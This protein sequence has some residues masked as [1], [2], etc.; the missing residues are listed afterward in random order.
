MFSR[1]LKYSFRCWIFI[2]NYSYL[3]ITFL[4]R[5]TNSSSYDLSVS[6][7]C[8]FFMVSTSSFRSSSVSSLL[9]FRLLWQ[10]VLPSSCLLLSSQLGTTAVKRHFAMLPWTC[11]RSRI[12]SSSSFSLSSTTFAK[13]YLLALR[14]EA[15]RFLRSIYAFENQ[16]A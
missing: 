9:E 14:H 3:Q 15:T 5:K 6:T 11:L 12:K 16:L 7:S 10:S 13:F 8:S 1:G 2:S 4:L